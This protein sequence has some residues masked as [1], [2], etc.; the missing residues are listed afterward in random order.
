MPF[1]KVTFRLH[2]TFLAI[3]FLGITGLAIARPVY[4]PADIEKK[5]YQ[6][7]DMVYSCVKGGGSYDACRAQ[8]TT[9]IKSMKR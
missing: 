9:A 4:R 3:I 1:D 6:L 8:L 7:Y 5:A 2:L